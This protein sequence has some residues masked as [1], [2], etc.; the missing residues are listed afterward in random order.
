MLALKQELRAPGVRQE[1]EALVL[2]D[3]IEARPYGA[4]IA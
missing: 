1:C 2:D 4:S 3:L